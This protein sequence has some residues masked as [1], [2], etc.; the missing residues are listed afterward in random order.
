MGAQS[1]IVLK[2]RNVLYDLLLWLNLMCLDKIIWF[3]FKQQFDVSPISVIL[4]YNF[5]II[6]V[7]YI[8]RN[9]F[10]VILVNIHMMLFLWPGHGA[11]ISRKFKIYYISH[12][13][14]PG[15]RNASTSQSNSKMHS[16]QCLKEL[17]TDLWMFSPKIPIN[18]IFHENDKITL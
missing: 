9:Y 6:S 15:S 4:L 11:C 17:N 13:R 10:S 7:T 16:N 2:Q 5:L 8:L 14:L 18:Y 3:D 1:V 12:F